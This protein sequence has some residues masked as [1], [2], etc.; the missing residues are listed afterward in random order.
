MLPNLALSNEINER[1]VNTKPLGNLGFICASSAQLSYLD[2]LLCDKLVSSSRLD[3]NVPEML[4]AFCCHD[5]G[6][7]RPADA[8]PFGKGVL[9]NPVSVKP[10]DFCDL[11]NRYFAEGLSVCPS[12]MA[13][14]ISNVLKPSSPIKVVNAIIC[15]T[16]VLM[17]GF[18][19]KRTGANKI[20]KHDLVDIATLGRES[21]HQM[22]RFNMGGA[23][24]LRP[25][26]LDWPKAVAATAKNVPITSHAV[27]RISDAVSNFTFWQHWKRRELVNV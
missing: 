18:L 23:F 13:H 1:L 4:P 11:L 22:P 9:I 16:S 12:A 14:G 20:P 5:N 25:V 27:A 10:T 26:R 17:A 19:A 24:Q 6:D 7:I 3:R 2:D 21:N 15:W 8:K